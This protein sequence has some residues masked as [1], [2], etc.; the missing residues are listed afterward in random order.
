MAGIDGASIR[1]VLKQGSQEPESRA[2]QVRS[3]Q[4][5]AARVYSRVGDG[6]RDIDAWRSPVTA[7]V[8]SNSLAERRRSTFPAG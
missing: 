7:D 8:V 5:A 6:D 2:T 1:S 4:R 3:G